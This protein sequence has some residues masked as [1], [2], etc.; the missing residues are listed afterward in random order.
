MIKIFK[1]KLLS[2]SSFIF[3]LSI[4]GVIVLSTYAN[5]HKIPF[6]DLIS[7]Q[8]LIAVG[9]AAFVLIILSSFYL[10]IAIWSTVQLSIF[11][12]KDNIS[13]KLTWKVLYIAY[14]FVFS[15][16]FLIFSLNV[17]E[18]YIPCAVALLSF[19]PLY[20]INEIYGKKNIMI[21]LFKCLIL[22]LAVL[23]IFCF[24]GF[25]F[26][27]INK[28]NEPPYYNIFLSFV[29]FLSLISIV[30]DIFNQKKS[31]IIIVMN[32]LE[33]KKNERKKLESK[34]VYFLSVGLVVLFVLP[35]KTDVSDN[36]IKFIGIGYEERCYYSQDL[37]GHKIPNDLIDKKDDISKIF[38]LSDI[39]N[40]IY[41]S[42]FDGTFF[43]YSFNY[44]KLNRIACPEFTK[45]K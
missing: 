2:I 29:L 5:R 26:L 39:S 9:G 44:E 32:S 14:S 13:N 30:P 3:L 40:K 28:I 16:G 45:N 41:L 24:G 33:K 17:D 43:S 20:F 23:F 10:A 22:F 31:K 18:Y 19:I 27:L 12:L 38:V 42:G 21:F 37:I 36:I 34:I 1:N 7:S 4:Y 11:M 15:V 8:V 25:V 35:L 6:Y